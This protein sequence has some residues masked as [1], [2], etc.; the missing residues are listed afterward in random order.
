MGSHTPLDFFKL[1]FPED[2]V[3]TVCQNT[4]KHVVNSLRKSQW[5]AVGISEFYKYLGLLFYTAIARSGSG[6]LIDYWRQNTIFTFPFPAQ[7]MGLARFLA[8][9]R[10]VQL[11]DPDEE[12]GNDGKKGTAEHDMLFPLKPL[13]CTVRGSCV[14]YQTASISDVN[15]RI[16]ASEEQTG[17]AKHVR[18]K[19]IRC[20]YDL[21]LISDWSSGYTVDFALERRKKTG[22]GARIRRTVSLLRDDYDP[23]RDAVL[24]D[25]LVQYHTRQQDKMKWYQ[26]MFL[27]LLE[28]A[29]GNVYILHKEHTNSMTHADFMTELITQLC[30]PSD[31]SPPEQV[32]GTCLPEVVPKLVSDTK[33]SF[34][35]KTCVYCRRVKSVWTCQ[36]CDVHLCLEAGCYVAWHMGFSL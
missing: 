24:S 17:L 36:R 18:G 16:V 19:S 6:D 33:S 14:A 26:K 20:G 1:F 12:R 31:N 7:I 3:E 35:K 32:R 22:L 2:A 8:L 28:I 23:V 34:V 29:A 9:T 5:K 10:Y 4:N 27:H 11:S 30:S 25:W 15:E 21:C 13:M